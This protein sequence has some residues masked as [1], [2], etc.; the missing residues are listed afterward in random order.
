VNKSEK[1]FLIYGLTES[2][3][4]VV[5]LEPVLDGLDDLISDFFFAVSRLYVPVLV[6]KVV[7]VSPALL[8]ISLVSGGMVD[9]VSVFGLPSLAPPQL[10]KLIIMADAKNTFFILLF[11]F[12]KEINAVSK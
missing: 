7:A 10:D 6:L 5:L 1:R 4:F 12:K 11:F 9:V 8:F 2:A 3:P